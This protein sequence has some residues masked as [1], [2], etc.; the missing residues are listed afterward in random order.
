VSSKKEK[1]IL[2]PV[3]WLLVVLS[4]FTTAAGP[5]PSCADPAREARIRALL[6]E[7]RPVLVCFVELADQSV[8][9]GKTMLLDR[10]KDDRALAARMAHL[11]MHL[12]DPIFETPGPDCDAW[13]DLVLQA[14]AR[15]YAVEIRALKKLGAPS[16]Y[17]F[18][19]MDAL[20]FLRAHPHGGGG[21][22]AL[23]D[24]YARRCRSGM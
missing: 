12:E 3:R 18:D 23:G 10:T 24:D 7:E 5:R 8:V 9:A 13:V 17:A 15:A 11:F 16:P 21:I 22:D 4:A 14:E 2:S 1:D 19:E 20:A 6:Q